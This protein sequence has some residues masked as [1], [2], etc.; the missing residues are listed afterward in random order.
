MVIPQQCSWMIRKIMEA[1]KHLRGDNTRR[2]TDF[3]IRKIYME[4]IG[5]VQHIEWTKLIAHKAAPSK[6]VFISW[7][8][9]HKG[10]ATCAYLQ[11][12][13]VRVDQQCCFCGKEEESVEHLFFACDYSGAV[14][15]QL[16]EWCKMPRRRQCWS[17]ERQHLLLQCRMNSGKQLMYTKVFLLWLCT[18]CGKQLMYRSVPSVNPL[19]SFHIPC[20]P[21]V[22][23]VVRKGKLVMAKSVV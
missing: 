3:S 11:K 4:L 20:F 23:E 19:H 9:M 15:E 6:F 5:E 21:S 14:W 12:I 8:L 13:G 1:R 10:L 17:L 22:E 2:M 18:C 7:L 16:T